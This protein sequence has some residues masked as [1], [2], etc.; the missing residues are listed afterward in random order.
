MGTRIGDLEK[1]VAELMTQAGMEEQA[2]S[3]WQRDH[4]S[5]VGCV[6]ALWPPKNMRVHVVLPAVMSLK[7]WLQRSTCT[8]KI[9]KW[10]FWV[11]VTCY[12]FKVFPRLPLL[13]DS[14]LTL[15]TQPDVTDWSIINMPMCHFLL[16]QWI[17]C[18]SCVYWVISVRQ[19]VIVTANVRA[20]KSVSCGG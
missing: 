9:L 17:F 11:D 8:W 15:N 12:D 13:I 18:F 20:W 7:S 3:K 14:V 16:S 4:C 6:F 19:G 5:S 10:D 1:N 2:I